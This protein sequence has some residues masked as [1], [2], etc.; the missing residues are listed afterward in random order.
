MLKLKNT[1]QVTLDKSIALLPCI[2]FSK[3]EVYTRYDPTDQVQTPDQM[4]L[5][6]NFYIG[7]AFF[8]FTVVM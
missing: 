6:D 7:S 4:T 5:L 2:D 1:D 8:K 3:K